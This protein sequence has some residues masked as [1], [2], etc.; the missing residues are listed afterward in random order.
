MRNLVAA[1]LFAFAVGAQAIPPPPPGIP[2]ER[3]GTGTLR[4]FGFH[5]YDAALYASDGRFDF[6]RPFAISIRYARELV[7][8]KIAERSL[9]EIER[10][11]L[12]SPAQRTA[13]ARAMRELFP[14]VADGDTLVGLHEPGRGAR[15][16]LNGRTLGEV[17]D[18]EFSRAFF[19]IWLDP[20]T[21]EPTLRAS[22][23]GEA[24]R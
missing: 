21:S 5:V 7:G 23:L 14:D 1:L 15:F 24:R 2:L 18:A 19:S 4:W 16:F 3:I 20:R 12:G 13:W 10:L 8:A 11:G 9:A 17:S 6:G 22:L